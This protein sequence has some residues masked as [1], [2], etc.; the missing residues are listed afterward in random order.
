VI[1]KTF[2]KT[3]FIGVDFPFKI[4]VCKIF[5]ERFSG[6]FNPLNFR[7]PFAL[8]HFDTAPPYACHSLKSAAWLSAVSA[9]HRIQMA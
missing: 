4:K 9:S 5:A 2:R 8:P 7:R 1:E 6:D 3:R